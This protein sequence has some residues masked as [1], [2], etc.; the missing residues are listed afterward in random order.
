MVALEVLNVLDLECFEEQIVES[1]QSNSVI[2]TESKHEGSEEI[3][4]ALDSGTVDGLFAFPE[5][6][7]FLFGVHTDL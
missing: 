6:D 1:Q 4:C 7:G 2:E 5:V 3:V